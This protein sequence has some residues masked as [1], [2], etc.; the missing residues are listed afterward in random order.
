VKLLCFCRCNINLI[1]LVLGGELR[2]VSSSSASE[3]NSRVPNTSGF[4]SLESGLEVGFNE[5]DF[6]S[7][8]QLIAVVESSNENVEP[9]AQF[10]DNANVE[11]QDLNPALPGSIYRIPF[12][13][14]S[15]NVSDQ[16]ESAPVVQPGNIRGDFLMFYTFVSINVLLRWCCVCNN[17]VV[18]LFGFVTII[19][20]LL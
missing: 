11:V 12:S 2:T 20:V 9:E 1:F 6:L 3:E 15:V 18:C 13:R 19:L 8:S 16:N 17:L 5:D 4:L 14:I 10:V 7:S